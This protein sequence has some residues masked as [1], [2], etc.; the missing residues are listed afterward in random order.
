MGNM[1]MIDANQVWDV[2]LAIEYVKRLAEIK[3]WFIGEPTAPD[4]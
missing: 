3:P 2:G 4:E 1:L